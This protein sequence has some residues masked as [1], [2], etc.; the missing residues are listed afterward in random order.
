VSADFSL[1]LP[2]YGGDRADHLIRAFETSVNEQTLAPAEV[3]IVRD[4]VV[5]PELST[6]IA[7][8]VSTSRV[9]VRLVELEENRGLSRALSE[10]L[11]R[12]SHEIVARMDAD[13]ESLPD[14]FEQQLRALVEDSLDLIGGGMVE[15]GSGSE[16]QLG[17]RIPPSGARIGPYARFHDPFNHPTVVYRREAVQRAGG[18]RDDTPMMEDY[19]LFARMIAAGARVDNLAVPVVRYR[20]DEGAYKRRGGLAQLRAELRLQHELRALGFTTRVQALR[21]VIVRGGYR[22]VPLAIRRATYRRVF[23]NGAARNRK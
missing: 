15:F 14:R 19:S 21:N 7:H 1:L 11:A 18:Y 2:V 20:V 5:S 6:A 13:D 3:V 16:R 9:P 8:L 4:G 22:L 12:C 23:A 17:V 10:G